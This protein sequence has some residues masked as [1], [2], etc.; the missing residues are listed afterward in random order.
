[1]K[2]NVI[3]FRPKKPTLEDPETASFIIGLMRG[4]YGTQK[5]ASILLESLNPIQREMLLKEVVQ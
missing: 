4:M 5:V 2:S 3:E 1:M